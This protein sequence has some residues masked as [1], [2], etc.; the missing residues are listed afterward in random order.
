MGAVVDSLNSLRWWRGYIVEAQ[1]CS[2]AG[3]REN[4]IYDGGVLEADTGSRFGIVLDW[5]RFSRLQDT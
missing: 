2:S 1:G 4:I 3:T 5:S